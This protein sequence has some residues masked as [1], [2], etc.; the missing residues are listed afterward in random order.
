MAG[1]DTKEII[2][3]LK[4]LSEGLE[5]FPIGVGCPWPLGRIFNELLKQ[6]RQ[7]V[8]D[9]PVLKGVRYLE[10]DTEGAAGTSNAS[11]GTVRALIDQMLLALGDGKPAAP[12]Q[13]PRA[14]ARAGAAKRSR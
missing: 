7:A 10:E 9:D 6:S 1:Q 14:A 3:R 5:R 11:A 4:V 12:A 8:E 13:K 2:Q